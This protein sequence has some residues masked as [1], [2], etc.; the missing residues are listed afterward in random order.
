[1][2]RI[3]LDWSVVSNLKR[4]EQKKLKEFIEDHKDYLQFPFSPA[5]FTD[6]MKSFS[7][8]NEYFY[9]DLE[10]LE[11]L[12]EKHLIR[13]ENN[14]TNA[15]FVTPKKYFEG[16]KNQEDIFTLMDMEKVTSELDKACETI[17][18]G[19]LGGLMKSLFRLQPAGIEVN[20]ENRDILQKMFP[21]I[22]SN[23]SMW[24][25]MKD[26]KPFSKNLLQN[27]E[28]Y[29]DIRKSLRDKGF[30]IESN[31]GNWNEEEVV[32]NIDNLLESLGTKMT[33]L[34]YVE[35]SFKHRKKPVNRYEFF[36]TAYLMLDMI[37]YKSDKLPKPTDNMQNIQTDG[38]HAFYG[39]HCDYFV[40]GDKNLR[41]KSKVLYNKF[42][43]PTQVLTPND[44]VESLEKVIHKIPAKT[45]DFL[46]E[47][48]SFVDSD[49]IVESYPSSDDIEAETY[50]LKLPLYYFNFFNY[51]VYRY[52]PT[53]EGI[54]LT[55]KK[56]FKNY[57]DFI[58]YTESER[59][60]DRIT[61]FFGYDDK[62]VLDKKKK[63][64][65]YENIDTQFIWNFKGGQIRLEKDSETRRPTLS[66]L[67]STKENK[68]SD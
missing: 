12:S 7:M 61:T 43:V 17:G 26:I 52:Y 32:K 22:T 28:Y 41:T 9:Q 58:F 35:S 18:L 3:Y 8:S 13:W 62:E 11:Y 54:V 4:P 55:F 30:K 49:R 39:A 27:R 38:E 23:T 40:V 21:N 33:F 53:Q 68:K 64:F 66:Y 36:T 37:G 57:S 20:E 44:L 45:D 47:A 31:S 19:K 24:D 10:T 42:N 6:L 29:K 2:I 50:A 25:L 60:I 59:L 15:L 65:V 51:I 46:R 67:I 14:R 1:M 48:I 34:E 5:H 16:E 56:V 63:E